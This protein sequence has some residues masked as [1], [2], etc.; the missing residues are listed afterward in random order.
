[1]DH[2]MDSARCCQGF[3]TFIDKKYIKGYNMKRKLYKPRRCKQCGRNFYPLYANE[4]VHAECRR[5]WYR[6]YNTQY[7]RNVRRELKRSL[8]ETNIETGA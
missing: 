8:M 2:R 5:R 1:M 7:Q 6:S 4:K 3:E